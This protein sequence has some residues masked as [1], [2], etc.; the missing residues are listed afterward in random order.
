MKASNDKY[1][2]IW[3][4]LSR[5]HW[6]KEV[7]EGLVYGY[8]QDDSRLSLT[9]LTDEQAE[10]LIAFLRAKAD[11]PPSEEDQKVWKARRRVIAIAHQL[12]W[13]QQEGGVMVLRHGQRMIDYARIEKWCLKHT[14]DKL[15]FFKKDSASLRKLAAQLDHVLAETMKKPKQ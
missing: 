2:T 12:G 6:G 14:A 13:Y 10:D 5:L 8:T 7:K 11:T 15:G 3:T 4:L 9:D 1:K